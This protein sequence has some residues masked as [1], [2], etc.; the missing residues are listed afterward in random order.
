MGVTAATP[1]AP[2]PHVWGDTGV[3]SVKDRLRALSPR[4]LALVEELA[5][6]FGVDDSPAGTESTAEQ[7]DEVLAEV[8][9]AG[10]ITST[11]ELAPGV[12]EQVTDGLP[13]HRRR[14][15]QR[16]V[17]DTLPECPTDDPDRFRRIAAAGVRDG[18]LADGLLAIGDETVETDPRSAVTFFDLAEGAGA[19]PEALLARRAEAALRTGDL[20]GAAELTDAALAVPEPTDPRRT[21]AVALAVFGQTGIV[22]PGNGICSWFGPHPTGTEA[23]SGAVVLLGQGNREEAQRLVADYRQGDPL[24]TLREGVASLLLSGLENS[25]GEAPAD[26]LPELVRAAQMMAA[27]SH[28]ELM[29]SHPAVLA[30]LVAL[31]VGDPVLAESVLTKALGSVDGKSR[32]YRRLAHVAAWTKVV[33]G[34]LDAAKEYRGAAASAEWPESTRDAFWDVALG[35]AIARRGNSARVLAAEWAVA[36]DRL[37][38][39]AVSLYDL[40]PLGELHIAA[41]RVKD[42]ATV[43]PHLR[44]AWSILTDLGSPPLWATSLHWDAIHGAILANAP[45]DVAP[46]A[47]A[48]SRAASK[49]PYA[50]DLASVG[51]VWMQVLAQKF[52]VED[53][54]QAGQLLRGH[55]QVWEAARL[56]GHAAARASD[57]RDT[58]RLLEYARE[59]GGKEA[60]SENGSRAGDTRSVDLPA[61]RVHLSSREQQVAR[62]VVNG[63]TYRETGAQLYLSERTV[64]HHMARIRQRFGVSSRTE[65]LA[66]LRIALDQLSEEDEG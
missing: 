6:G 39:H 24:P 5:V 50:A 63:H 3:G 26:V 23:A 40:L 37:M 60:R 14:R 42:T 17:L 4:A 21:A 38:S 31:H 20:V 64:E 25:L 55:G 22:A 19:L 18:R 59:V 47:S 58:A 27:G 15:L 7:F 35:V 45:K 34:D 33:V 51:R 49:L 43:T 62:L 16:Q 8:E 65:L 61:G 2:A 53:V 30:A 46:H 12:A 9:G 44:S 66:Q 11:G 36:R 56:A 1:S 48:L 28:D 52:A 13:L 41:V 29:P 10:L 54:I 57:R 32:W